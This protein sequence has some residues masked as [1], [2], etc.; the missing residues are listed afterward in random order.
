M[1]VIRNQPD[2][3]RFHDDAQPH[4][5]PAAVDI[6][7]FRHPDK[8]VGWGCAHPD[9]PKML[10]CSECNR[11]DQKHALEHHDSILDFQQ[12]LRVLAHEI[13]QI[14]RDDSALFNQNIKNVLQNANSL[15]EA[16]DKKCKLHINR[17]NAE[18]DDCITN[19]IQQFTRLKTVIS[20]FFD[21][22]YHQYKNNI[23]YFKAQYA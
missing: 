4:P 18:V 20:K 12:F 19:T 3:L 9:C 11:L 14:S 16:F 10:M 8:K 23:L 17:F 13:A 2:L 22:Q 7:C 15:Q 5:L 1:N 21:R 6:L